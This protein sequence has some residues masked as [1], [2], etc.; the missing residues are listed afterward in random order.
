MEIVS[1]LLAALADRV[2]KERFELWFGP[3]THIEWD[4]QVLMIG[5]ANQFFLDWIRANFRAAIEEVGQAILGRRPTLEF[6][7]AVSGESGAVGEERE[8]L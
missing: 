6:R 5:A 8:R 7:V 3:R 1:A 2:G 4:G